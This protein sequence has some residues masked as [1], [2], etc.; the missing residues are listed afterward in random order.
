LPDDGNAFLFKQVLDQLHT[1]L[2]FWPILL[3][4]TFAYANVAQRFTEL[5]HK[6][7]EF[8]ANLGYNVGV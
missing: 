3:C 7:L 1:A 5:M 2:A 4:S 6:I 8:K